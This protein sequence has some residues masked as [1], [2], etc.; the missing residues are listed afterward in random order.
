[1][2]NSIFNIIEEN[3][4]FKRYRNYN[5]R[6]PWHSIKRNETEWSL[7]RIEF[8]DVKD[9]IAEALGVSSISDEDLQD[10]TTGPVI[11]KEHQKLIKHYG[12]GILP[13]GYSQS[14]FQE[15]E[16]CLRTKVHLAAEALN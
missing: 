1:M 3:N 12:Y 11:N 14:I 2:Y 9:E 4:K 13:G 8:E 10:E 16:S 5:D 15:F 7:L 6:F